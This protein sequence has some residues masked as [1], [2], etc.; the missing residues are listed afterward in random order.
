MMIVMPFNIDLFWFVILTTHDIVS[1]RKLVGIEKTSL[2]YGVTN[3]IGGGGHVTSGVAVE[4]KGD[5]G[6]G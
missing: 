6:G 4:Q 2:G 5:T 3:A 1:G